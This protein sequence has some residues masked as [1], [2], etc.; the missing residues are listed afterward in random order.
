MNLSQ[1]SS[2]T[3]FKA[4]ALL[5]PLLAA[6]AVRLA[7][8]TGPAA[9]RAQAPAPALAPA[10][11]QAPLTQP[12]LAAI[13][14]LSQPDHL[15]PTTSPLDRFRPAQPTAPAPTPTPPPPQPTSSDEPSGLHITSLMG[16]DRA[17]LIGID[18]K[19]YRLGDEVAPKWRITDVDPDRRVI[20]LTHDDG[21][22][23]E[24]P[25]D[26]PADEHASRPRTR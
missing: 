4:A 13:H 7:E 6:Q 17:Y 26:P 23:T 16:R 5:L 3:Y 24:I 20:I 18:H 19:T 21:R 1:G 11:P 22:T 9:A 25:I 15:H 12:Q 10:P 2:A 8:F 14:W